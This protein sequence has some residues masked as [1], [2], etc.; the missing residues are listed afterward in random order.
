MAAT[1]VTQLLASFWLTQHV[2][3]RPPTKH[4]LF[5]FPGVTNNPDLT[6]SSFKSND[7]NTTS[8][9][10]GG[11]FEWLFDSYICLLTCSSITSKRH[12]VC[13]DCRLLTV[14]INVTLTTIVTE[15]TSTA[16][17]RI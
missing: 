13:K 5:A 9:G 16:A 15:C 10:G 17:Y 11:N 14:P 7:L 4:C 8:H 6:A 12:A 1:S 2:N 3:T